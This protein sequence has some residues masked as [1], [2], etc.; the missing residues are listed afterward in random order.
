[1]RLSKGSARLAFVAVL[2]IGAVGFGKHHS[3]SQGNT[4]NNTQNTPAPAATPPPAATQPSQLSQDE[5]AQ[6]TASATLL[7]AQAKLKELSDAD[8]ATF[9]QTPDWTN[10]QTQ[11][12]SAQTELDTAKSAAS[13]ALAN[14]PDYQAAVAAKKKAVD[15]LAAAK[16]GDDATPETL[17]PLA[18][19]SLQATLNLRKITADVLANDTGVAV[20]TDKLATAQHAVDLLKLK[21]QQSLLQDKNY[22]VAQAAVMAA[23]SAYDDAR[24]K[25]Q[26]S[27]A[28]G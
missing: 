5:S 22:A 13:D 12:T 15:D 6:S 24:Q 20:A 23:Q 21:F 7:A 26:S 16:A 8:W 2:G 27:N 18:T 17:A 1:M 3:N 9:Q 14:S 19:A 28:G 10:A 4:N 25:V 11:L